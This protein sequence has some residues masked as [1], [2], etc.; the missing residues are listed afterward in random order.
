MRIRSILIL[1]MMLLL[2]SACG[3]TKGKVYED[4]DIAE[5][6]KVLMRVGDGKTKAYDL[7]S[8]DDCVA[9]RIPGF[10]CMRTMRDG[11]ERTVEEIAT[12]LI[13][14][15]G[16]KYNHLIIVV[17]YDGTDARRFAEIMNASGYYNIHY[18]AGGYDRYVALKGDDFV[19]ETGGCD[20]C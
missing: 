13:L 12:D 1:I 16:K 4:A 19:P 3:R 7:R 20:G 5:F 14:L 18:F 6:D 17:D 11:K 2:L 9:G 15:L 10:F 8:Y